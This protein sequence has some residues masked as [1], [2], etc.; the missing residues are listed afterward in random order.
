VPVGVTGHRTK[1]PRGQVGPPG[2]HPAHPSSLLDPGGERWPILPP[3]APLIAQLIAY[4]HALPQPHRS[5][6]HKPCSTGIPER[7]RAAGGGRAKGE[8]RTGQHLSTCTWAKR[9][10]S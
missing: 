10:I 5:S 7:G 2:P 1:R 3:L 8:K 4:V 9:L 6:N